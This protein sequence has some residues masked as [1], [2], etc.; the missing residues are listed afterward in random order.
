MIDLME[1]LWDV[2]IE[3]SLLRWFFIGLL[4]GL[5]LV[6]TMVWNGSDMEAGEALIGIVASGFLILGARVLLWRIQG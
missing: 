6:G 5:F 2:L 1:A 4:V 3:N